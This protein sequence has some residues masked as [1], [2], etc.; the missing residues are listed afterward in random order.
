MFTGWKRVYHSF[1]FKVSLTQFGTQ[2]VETVR[3]RNIKRGLMLMRLLPRTMLFPYYK[4]I[5][6]KMYYL[7]TN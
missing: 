6:I 1:D 5:S 3:S 4:Y 7:I 2:S